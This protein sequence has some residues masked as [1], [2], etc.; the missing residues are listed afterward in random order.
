M[1][2][3]L[4]LFLAFFSATAWA[5]FAQSTTSP[6]QQASPIQ[7]SGVVLDQETKKPLAYA[8]VGILDEPVGTLTNEQGEFSFTVPVALTNKLVRISA[9]GYEATQVSTA[10]LIRTATAQRRIEITLQAK[11]V[12][13]SEVKVKASQWK[14]KKLG[15]NAGPNT[16]FH[17]NFT[18]FQRPLQESLGREVGVIIPNGN[19]QTFLSKLNFCISNNQ[20]EELKFRVNLY[21]V[22]D[23]QPAESLSSKEILT[24]V[25]AVKKGWVQVD[26]E[27]YNVF[28]SQD[29]VIALEWIG[30]TPLTDA[31]SLTLAAT[32]PGF[33]TTFY[34]DASQAKW[35][36]MS[37]VGVGL[38]VEVQRAD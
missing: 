7:L 36:K 21:A 28:V 23:G 14:K 4:A 24:T 33:H 5:P 26:L 10:D 1:K 13:L 15:G 38:N 27:P 30:G 12:E 6:L 17:H 20:F 11:P 9:I 29:F 22:K 18:A 3:L 34:K 8:S 19:Q 2:L 37:A 25:K 16:I 32:L 35:A 31:K